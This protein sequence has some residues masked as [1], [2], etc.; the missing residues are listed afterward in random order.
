[1]D[2]QTRSILQKLLDANASNTRSIARLQAFNSLQTHVIMTLISHMSEGTKF[3]GDFFDSY[4]SIRQTALNT[5]APSND[6][7]ALEPF[8]EILDERFR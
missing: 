8:L 2:E 6:P 3:D 7:N 4:E 5:A 1:M